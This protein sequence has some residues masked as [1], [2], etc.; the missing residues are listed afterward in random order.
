[1]FSSGAGARAASASPSE[2]RAASDLSS[3]CT[4]HEATRVS[5][6]LPDRS[7]R[8]RIARDHLRATGSDGRGQAR[9]HRHAACR[10]RGGE[11]PPAPSLAG[12]FQA[13]PP[14]D[15]GMGS[16]RQHQSESAGMQLPGDGGGALAAAPAGG[17]PLELPDRVVTVFQKA[18]AVPKSLLVFVIRGYQAFVSPLLGRHCRYLPSCSE[19]AAMSL[20][21]WGVIRGSWL[22]TRRVLRC[23][24][25]SATGLD[26]PP[27]RGR[28]ESGAASGA[29]S[30][31]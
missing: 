6:G 28:N 29:A 2:Q 15:E 9:H 7:S 8:A 20:E 24:P 18:M 13:S 5:G 30:P 3:H 22:A 31:R 27:R 17:A 4:S 11:K 16:R 1:V 12:V 23:H 21:E 10:E 25:W 19:Y 14:P 26:L